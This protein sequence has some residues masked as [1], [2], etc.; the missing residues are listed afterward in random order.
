MKKSAPS[1]TVRRSLSKFGED[2]RFA[3]LRRD[4]PMAL[5][6]QR[7]KISLST[8]GKIEDGDPDVSLGNYAAAM[9]ALN[10]GTPFSDL[11]DPAKDEVGL[12]LDL[13]NVP[14]RA[15]KRVAAKIGGGA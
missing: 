13:E 9:F 7:A 12:Q 10:L 4:L 1:L 14:K 6:A 15:R 5:V 8:L 11:V 3:R 2:L